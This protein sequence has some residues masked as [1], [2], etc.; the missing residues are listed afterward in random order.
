MDIPLGTYRHF[1]GCVYE[2]IGVAK[3]SEDTQEL[4]IYKRQ[5]D[6]SLWARPIAMWNEHVDRDGYVGPRFVKI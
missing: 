2:V 1:K 4:V 5:K 3:H 6:D